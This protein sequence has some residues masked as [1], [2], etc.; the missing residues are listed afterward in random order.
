MAEM[1]AKAAAAAQGASVDAQ[2]APAAADQPKAPGAKAT[3]T[4][5]FPRFILDVRL[6]VRMFQAGEF[7]TCWGRSTEMGQDG[8]GATLT[9]DLEAGEIVTLEIPL[10]L[11]AYPIKVRA[12][13][14]YRQGL[15]YGFEFL[16][17]NTGQRDTI[18]RVCEYLAT[19]A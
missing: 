8:I 1:K 3:F 2:G 5:R 19:K 7:R 10:P 13:V 12:I 11:S 18:Q 15:K 14:R 17:L 6:Q 16:T 4:R 9:G